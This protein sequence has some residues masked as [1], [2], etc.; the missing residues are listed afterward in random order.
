MLRYKNINKENS[1][2]SGF[3]TLRSVL[4]R[5]FFGY[6]KKINI[7]NKFKSTREET[8]NEIAT[9]DYGL[10]TQDHLFTFTLHAF[11][12]KKNR[13]W[14]MSVQWYVFLIFL[15]ISY[16]PYYELVILMMI[17]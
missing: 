17:S 11:V 6:Q 1:K 5:I 12:Y 2:I 15:K 9:M 14:Y 16:F 8:K 7:S 13:R 10:T 3:K 4:L